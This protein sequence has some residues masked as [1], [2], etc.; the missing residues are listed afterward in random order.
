MAKR[1]R[2]PKAANRPAA[3]AAAAR[4]KS[5]RLPAIV[6]G[7][8][9]AAAAL[10]AWRWYDGRAD[11]AAFMAAAARGAG[12]LPG[13]VETFPSAGREHVP[14]G[15]PMRYPAPFPTSG[16]HW[17]TWIDPGR[18]DEPQQPAQLVHS[19]EHGMIVVYYDRPPAACDEAIDTWVG[20]YGGPWSG[21]VAVPYPGL[22]ETLMLSAWTR[23]LR[24][25]NCATET[26]LA[27]AF[28]DA[29]RGRGPEHPVR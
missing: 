20:L 3:G 18:Y 15:T 21:V 27:A 1:A 28:I 29:Y 8:A 7:V 4:A 22:G 17:T 10:G 9:L 12:A 26:D 14:P 5:R 19:L 23:N 13:R 25:E 11:E 6:A 2:K 24:L 16:T